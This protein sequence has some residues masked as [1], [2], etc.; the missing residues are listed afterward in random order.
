[1]LALTD[2]AVDVIKQVVE[3]S[4]M[5][6]GAGLRIASQLGAGTLGAVLAEA[7]ELEDEVVEVEGARVFLDPIA[8]P[9]LE[10]MVLDAQ[11]RPTGG[12]TFGV[13]PQEP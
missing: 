1:M 13:A 2:R 12:V 11:V 9:Q 6:E 4:D 5:P 7:P 3:A 10:D 8:N